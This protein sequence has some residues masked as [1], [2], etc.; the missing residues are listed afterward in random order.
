MG[1][2]IKVESIASAA[3]AQVHFRLDFNMVAN[4]VNP[5]LGGSSLIWVKNKFAIKATLENKHTCMF[6]DPVDMQLLYC[7]C[8]IVL[9]TV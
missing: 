9:V 1:S 2:L 7:T 4:T 8:I 5:D 6:S 3:S